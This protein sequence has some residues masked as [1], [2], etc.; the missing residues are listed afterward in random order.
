MSILK[1]QLT[2][3]DV[4]LPLDRFPCISQRELFKQALEMMNEKKLGIV[5]IVN[6]CGQLVG[7]LTDGDIRRNL[8]SDQK[9]LAALFVDDAL[10]HA[11]L[12]PLTVI[13]QLPLASAVQIMEDRQVWD[14]PVVDSDRTL[15]GLLHLHPAIMALLSL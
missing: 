2:V 10:E 14:L 8:L 5:C 11:V 7:V 3:A 15:L 13:P 4:M 1:S 6:H 12:N 9:P